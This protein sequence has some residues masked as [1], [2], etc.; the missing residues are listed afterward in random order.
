MGAKRWGLTWRALGAVLA[1]VT[2]AVAVATRVDAPPS[3]AAQP[4]TVGKGHKK[5]CTK[6]PKDGEANCHADVVTDD[7]GAPLATSN[8]LY[9]FA[10]AD[11]HAAYKLPALPAAGTK[12]AWNGQ[13]IAIVNAYNDPQ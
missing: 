5:V 4:T 12:W 9:G 3:H 1:L 2:G 11:L 7:K 6:K 13:T 10:P 8:Y